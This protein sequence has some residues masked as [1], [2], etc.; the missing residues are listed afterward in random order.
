MVR[1]IPMICTGNYAMVRTI[2]K[3][4]HFGQKN[5]AA[6]AADTAST[7]DPPGDTL[8]VSAPL[9]GR[10]LLVEANLCANC[11]WSRTENELPSTLRRSGD[12]VKSNFLNEHAHWGEPWL[13]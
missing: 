13:S 3:G 12:N 5:E 10:C 1:T 4:E 11:R 8:L 6:P 7:R 2:A 9:Y